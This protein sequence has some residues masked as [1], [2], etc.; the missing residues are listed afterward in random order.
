[1]INPRQALMP[2]VI[3]FMLGCGS[4]LKPSEF[5]KFIEDEKNGFSQTN[6]TDNFSIKCIYTPAAYLTV[7]SYKSDGITKAEFE[8]AEAGFHAFDM[9]KLEISTPDTRN[10]EGMSEYFSFY[11]QDNISK[12]CGKDTFPCIVYH[13]EPFS[14]IER[15]QRIEIGFENSDCTQEEIVLNNTPLH[16][17]PITFSFDKKAL[18][19]P[20]I[21][22]K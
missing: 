18:T 5:K 13:A 11:M 12:T 21:S 4:G 3:I 15:K 6:E 17:S 1:M 16:S 20:P 19:I 9:Y 7:L 8:R 14:S 2:F 10:V 22:L